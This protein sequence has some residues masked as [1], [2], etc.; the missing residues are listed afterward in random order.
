LLTIGIAPSSS[1]LDVPYLTIPGG[2]LQYRIGT[3]MALHEAL[4]TGEAFSAS[5]LLEHS[6][7]TD[8]KDDE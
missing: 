4:G 7:D 5:S 8:R 1:S 6:L 3:S 2:K